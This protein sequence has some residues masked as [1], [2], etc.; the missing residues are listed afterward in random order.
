ME[1]NSDKNSGNKNDVQ[2]NW[3]KRVGWLIFIWSMSV[4]TLSVAAYSIKKFM[5]AAGMTV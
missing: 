3:F 5:S 1:L 4:L 2:P